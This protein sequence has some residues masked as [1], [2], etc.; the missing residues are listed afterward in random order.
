MTLYQT[1]GVRITRIMVSR[2]DPLPLAILHFLGGFIKFL[3]KR[4]INRLLCHSIEV[5]SYVIV[6]RDPL[7]LLS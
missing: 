2:K 3:L 7:I 6:L 5:E 4:F 1:H